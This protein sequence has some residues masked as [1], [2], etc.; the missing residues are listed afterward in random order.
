M[1]TDRK[2]PV[3]AVDTG[4]LR[5]TPTA[6]MASTVEAG[7][8]SRPCPTDGLPT[9]CTPQPPRTPAAATT[10]AAAVV[11]SGPTPS[12]GMRTARCAVSGCLT[13][14]AFHLPCPDPTPTSPAGRAPPVGGG[15]GRS[16]SG[17]TSNGRRGVP[18]R[19]LRHGVSDRG[20]APAHVELVDRTDSADRPLQRAQRR[21][22]EPA[23]YGL[24]EGAPVSQRDDGP[25]LTSHCLAHP[26]DVG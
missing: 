19:E 5:A 7:S 17:S 11:T 25:G 15:R 22:G 23:C 26:V 8:A 2:P 20:G 3:T 14:S 24:D 4:P 18:G 1:L 6:R 12:P 9:S 16:R 10:R 21:I 13:R